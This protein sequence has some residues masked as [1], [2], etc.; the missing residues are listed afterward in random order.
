[1]P[2]TLNIACLS[3]RHGWHMNIEKCKKIPLGSIYM[4]K[5]FHQLPLE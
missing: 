1:M 2:N 4:Q 3:R 5:L